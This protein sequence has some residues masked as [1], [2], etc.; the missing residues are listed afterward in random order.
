MSC[1][2]CPTII[3]ILCQLKSNNIFVCYAITSLII[4]NNKILALKF[5]CIMLSNVRHLN[6]LPN[7]AFSLVQCCER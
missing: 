2:E 7:N 5:I 4:N 1:R 3:S 6:V